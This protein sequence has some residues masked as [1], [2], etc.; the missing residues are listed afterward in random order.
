MMSPLS[1][2]K[3][4]SLREEALTHRSFTQELKLK[5]PDNERLEFLGDALLDWFMAEMLMKQFPLDNEGTLS[6]KRASLVNEEVLSTKARMLGLDKQIKLGPAEARTGGADKASLLSD[7]FEAVLA[8]I[9]LDQGFDSAKSWLHKIF[10][11]DVVALENKEFE[12]DYKSRFQ[13]WAQSELKKTPIYILTQE[14]GPAHLREF[15]V[16]VKIDSEAWGSGVGSSKKKAEQKAAEVALMRKTAVPALA[17][18]Q[19]PDS[20]VEKKTA[21]QSS[22]SSTQPQPLV[23]QAKEGVSL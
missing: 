12:K 17:S 6:K 3:N 20:K 14:L 5:M 7:T 13:E 1:M 10:N 2:I 11:D 22:A 21:Q 15:H 8:A 23:A 9:Y 4:S 16:D 19:K 18:E